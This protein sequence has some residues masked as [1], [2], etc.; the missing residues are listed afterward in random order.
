MC[1]IIPATC[2]SSGIA[3]A[4]PDARLYVGA[5]GKSTARWLRNYLGKCDW[6]RRHAYFDHIQRCRPAS[7]TTE[8]RACFGP[9]SLLHGTATGVAAPNVI[10][11]QNRAKKQLTLEEVFALQKKTVKKQLTLPEYFAIHKKRLK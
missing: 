5:P 4:M 10:I 3:L 8:L 7:F 2:Q 11:L 1:C 6:V 9:D